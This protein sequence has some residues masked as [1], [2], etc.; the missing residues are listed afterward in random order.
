MMMDKNE[1]TATVALFDRQ[2]GWYYVTVPKNLCQPYY[3]LQDRGLIA[4]T[5]SA[6]SGDAQVAWQ[7]S[8][9]PMGDGSHFLALP[10]KV[11][12]RLKIGAGDCVEITF[13]IRRR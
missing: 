10:A 6:R 2:G 3:D 8:L 5:A 13:S 1:F 12:N 9:L 4:V 7:T 11:R